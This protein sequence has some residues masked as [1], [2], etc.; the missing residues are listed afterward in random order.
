MDSN[1]DNNKN[2]KAE[3]NMDSNIENCDENSIT[4][5]VKM[6]AK[7]LYDYLLNHAYT[8]SSGIIG[9][10]FGVVGILFFL[11]T[12]Y[13]LYLIIGIM[14]ILY[15]PYTLWTQAARTMTV[16]EAYKLPL[17]Y[18]L[19]SKGITVSQG[20]VSETASWDQCTK[21]VSTKMSI[22]VY[23]GKKNAFVFPRAQLLDKLTPM[24]SVIAENM[25]PKKVKIRF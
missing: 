8:G 11:R 6:S 1:I 5:Q 25:D 15:L 4:F 21:A 12:S 13:P 10:C 16:N 20:E 9:T 14:L 19:D 17:T 23:T 22:V 7:I 2:N 3:N 18:T 24:L